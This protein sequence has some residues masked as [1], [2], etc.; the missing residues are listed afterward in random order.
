MHVHL[1]IDIPTR[2]IERST[3]K[4]VKVPFHECR[5]SEVKVS[6]IE[7]LEL[8]R[9]I[10]REIARKVGGSE[11]CTHFV[12]ILQSAMRFTSANLIGIEVDRV[13]KI[14]EERATRT[15]EILRGTCI[16]FNENYRKPEVKK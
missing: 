1:I 11:G 3:G 13:S 4:M 5:L 14:P 12:E 2:R 8:K 6:A 7:G 15:F 9:G 16:A 10:N